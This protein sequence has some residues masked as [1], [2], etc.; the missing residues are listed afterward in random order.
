M[1]GIFETTLANIVSASGQ[2]L[3][4]PLVHPTRNKAGYIKITAEE[5]TGL[6]HIVKMTYHGRDLDKKDFFGKSDPYY[7]I[8]RTME[9][10]TTTVVY[11]SDHIKN[12]L[13]PTWTPA[14]VPVAQLCNGDLDRQLLFEGVYWYQL[15]IL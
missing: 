3:Q 5:K 6:K 11:R 2:A 15:A 1:L 8:S 14:V 12:T 9:D 13:N 7:Q 10:G 4:K